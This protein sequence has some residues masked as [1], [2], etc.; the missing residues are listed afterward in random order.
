H[1]VRL[2]EDAPVRAAERRGLVFPPDADA[3]ETLD[4]LSA[5]GFRQVLEASAMV[6]RWLGGAPRALKGPAA[7]AVFAELVPVLVDHTARAE[8]PDAALL[9]FDRFLDNLHGGARLFSLLRQNP[10][11]VALVARVLGTAPRL[12]DT[13]A[14]HPQ[15]MDALTD[16][17]FFGAL[18]GPEK[19]EA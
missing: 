15:V 19:L 4:K 6:R 2:F 11:L 5:M 18:P 8:N 7:R 1:Y 16:P 12:A 10:A 13:L 9:P 3:H 14:Q 17:A